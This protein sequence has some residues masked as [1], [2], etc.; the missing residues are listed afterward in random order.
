MSPVFFAVFINSLI[1]KLRHAG[2]G[3][4]LGLDYVGCLLYADD[5]MP[6]AHSVTV[7][8]AMLDICSTEAAEWD[9][10][11]MLLNQLPSG[12]AFVTT[13]HVPPCL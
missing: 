6:I 11:S 9:F 10:A 12:L 2:L 13:A 8:Q 3:A 7:M 4:F 5:I 1:V